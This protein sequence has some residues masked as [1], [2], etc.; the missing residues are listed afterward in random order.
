[1]FKNNIFISHTLQ[2][3]EL[4]KHSHEIPGYWYGDVGTSCLLFQS[5]N[6]E[7]NARVTTENGDNNYIHLAVEYDTKYQLLYIIFY[8]GIN[9]VGS[10]TSEVGNNESLE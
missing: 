9:D 4:P 2:V 5:N 3:N 7:I 1:M 10:P 8:L 6:T